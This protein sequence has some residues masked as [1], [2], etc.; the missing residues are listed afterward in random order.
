MRFLFLTVEYPPDK[1]GISTYIKNEV[2]QFRAAKNEVWIAALPISRKEFRPPS[3]YASQQFQEQQNSRIKELKEIE[4][5]KQLRRVDFFFNLIRPR[6]LRLAWYLFHDLKKGDYDYFVVHHVLPVG[7]VA[8]L[9]GKIKNIPYVLHIHGLDVSM[10]KKSR[11]KRWW[12]RKIISEAKVVVA[13]SNFARS[14]FDG[15][16]ARKVVVAYPCPN[17]NLI[18]KKVSQ[19]TLYNMRKQYVLGKRKVL[20][21]VARLVKRK[22]L[23]AV[24]EALP[25]ILKADPGIVWCVVGE[26]E[27]A[28]ELIKIVAKHDLQFASRFVGPVDWD[29]LAAWFTIADLFVMPSITISLKGGGVDVEGWGIVYSEAALFG[30]AVIAGNAGGAPEAVLDGKTGVLVDGNK[31]DEVGG[32]IIKLMKDEKLR[33]TLGAAAKKR[34]ETEFTWKEQMGKILAALK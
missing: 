12:L 30:K 21:S 26:G 20:L 27:Y 18:G 14:T 32:A 33:D 6:W 19:D 22:G 7:Q 29:S 3:K 17:T 9:V 23:Q 10:A 5:D 11:W 31:P 24:A 4:K 2:D 1:G 25:E 15:Y 13:N 28:D 34:V 16:L 8:W